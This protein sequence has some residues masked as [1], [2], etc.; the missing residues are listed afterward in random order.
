L[1]KKI[2]I[3]EP[4]GSLGAEIIS[5]CLPNSKIII[6]LRDGRDV[7][8][9]RLDARSEKGWSTKDGWKAIAKKDRIPFIE[10]ESKIWVKIM[11]NLM[12]TYDYHE[13][14]NIVLLKYEEL[15]GNT[16]EK[17][18]QIFKKIEIDIDDKVIKK[19]VREQEFKTWK[20]N[21]KGKGQKFR[22]A[23]PGKWEQNLNEQEREIMNKIMETTLKKLGYNK[24]YIK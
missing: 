8:D 15:L 16:F 10:R 7:I 3:K 21:P 20:K 13:K 24:K 19:I 23:S 11:N 18:K 12:K 22:S 4:N 6:L 17:M 9:S 14:R 2:V 5:Y 1:N